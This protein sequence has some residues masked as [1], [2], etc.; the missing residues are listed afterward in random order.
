MPI[1]L[2][3][4]YDERYVLTDISVYEDGNK[5]ELVIEAGYPYEVCKSVLGDYSDEIE[6]IFMDYF[7][8]QHNFITPI[9]YSYSELY[10]GEYVLLVEKSMDVNESVFGIT[11]LEYVDG[12]VQRID[13]SDCFNTREQL[14][15]YLRS[16]TFEKVKCA[17]RYGELKKCNVD[18]GGGGNE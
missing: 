17:D 8:N 10:V 5:K 6:M 7:N 16:L 1:V 9:P 4:K 12:C 3:V 2:E 11:F 15:D 14:D 13:L 18:I